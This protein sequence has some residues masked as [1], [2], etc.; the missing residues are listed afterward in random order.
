MQYPFGICKLVTTNSY[1]ILEAA[2]WR[3]PKML[4]KHREAGKKKVRFF[5]FF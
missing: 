3:C 5:V 1:D 2:C 4:E